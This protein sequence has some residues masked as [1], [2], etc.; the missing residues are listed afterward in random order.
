VQATGT[1]AGGWCGWLELVFAWPRPWPWV[2]FDSIQFGSRQSG[3]L[4][5]IRC[6]RCLSPSLGDNVRGHTH[7]Q[8][9]AKVLRYEG[10]GFLATGHGRST[11]NGRLPGL[12]WLEGDARDSSFRSRRLGRVR[13][14][15]GDSVNGFTNKGVSETKRKGVLEKQASIRRWKTGLIIMDGKQTKT[16]IQGRLGEA[17]KAAGRTV[18]LAASSLAVPSP[19]RAVAG[20]DEDEDD[21]PVI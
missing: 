2:R 13:C 7:R 1:R 8:Q 19:E 4:Q 18:N 3:S 20:L 6:A 15:P 11:T 17:D 14:T 21:D 16:R 10:G 12:S 9:C 5:C